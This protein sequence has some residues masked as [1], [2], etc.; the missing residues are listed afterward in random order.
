MRKLFPICLLLLSGSCSKNNST[1]RDKQDQAI[2]PTY[3]LKADSNISIQNDTVFIAQE[4]YSGF[5]Y[6]LYPN[7]VDTAF[8]ESYFNGV[9]Y[10]TSKKWYPNKQLME[11][12]Q[13]Y[14][15][16]KHGKQV[17][18]WEN[19]NKKF[20]FTAIEDVY[21]GE[22]KEWNVDGHLIHL[23]NYKNGHEDGSQKLWYDNGKIRA[24]YVIIEGKRYGLLG[25]KNC[26][27]VSD[28]IFM[29]R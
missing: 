5:L 7:Q 25:T 29:A 11:Q 28:S 10:G 23:A 8:V 16:R 14:K 17:A 3:T 4:R 26:I 1:A 20:E 9:L 27:N 2:P 13:Y 24:N 21:E 15:G 19:G 18:Y 12:R 6:Q 22:L